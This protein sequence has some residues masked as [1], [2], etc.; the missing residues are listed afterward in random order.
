MSL[1][2]NVLYILRN[3]EK[4]ICPFYFH[5]NLYI[6]KDRKVWFKEELCHQLKNK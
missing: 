1:E 5:F 4:V 6:L 2:K 3:K